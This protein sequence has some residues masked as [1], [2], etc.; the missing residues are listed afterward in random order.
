MSNP[1]M[2]RLQRE[3]EN[4]A[5]GPAPAGAPTQQPYNPQYPYQQSQG[6]QTQGQQ[7]DQQ[8]QG[9][10]M[11]DQAAFQQ[12]QES[13]YAPAV[14]PAEIGR[15]TWD[16]VIVKTGLNLAVLIGAGA[17]TWMLTMSNPEISPLLLIGGLVVGLVTAMVNIFSRTIRPALILLYSA[18]EG[19][20]LGALSA[21]TEMVLPGV[22]IQA[23]IATAVVFAVTLALFASGKVR[24]SPKMMKFV[25]ISL[26]GIIVSRLAIMLF[27][28]FGW[29]GMQNGGYEVTLLG[30]P[31]PILIS[32]FAVV[33][34]AFCLIGDFDQARV[35]VEQGAP[36]KFAWSCAF[37]IM[38][39]VVW[40]YIEILNILS[41]VN[42]R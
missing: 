8:A 16:D 23:A 19:V 21:V 42:S 11:Y 15:M 20:A 32:L 7:W 30:I 6:Q 22:V 35:G 17:V 34:G 26:I 14:T 12:A 38:V 3:W 39:T 36:A 1:V 24:N 28:S 41:Y 31:L 37:G 27:S 13:Y 9:A 29:L 4:P 25:L 2:N 5:V 10:P 40:L 18:A 33:V